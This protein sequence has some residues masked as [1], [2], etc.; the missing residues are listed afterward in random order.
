LLDSSAKQTLKPGRE[1]DRLGQRRLT[2]ELNICQPGGQFK[3]RER[4]P[5]SSG[6]QSLTHRRRRPVRR[7]RQ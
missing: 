6:E 2:R 3:Q 5:G 4:V 1:R 7:I